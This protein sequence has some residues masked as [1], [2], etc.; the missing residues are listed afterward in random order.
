MFARFGNSSCI[1]IDKSIIKIAY[2]GNEF[3]IQ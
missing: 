1:C 2:N 3:L